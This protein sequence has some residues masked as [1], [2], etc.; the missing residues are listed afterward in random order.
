LIKQIATVTCT[1]TAISKLSGGHWASALDHTDYWTIGEAWVYGPVDSLVSGTQTYIC[2]ENP[3]DGIGAVA[4]IKTLTGDLYCV[5]SVTM[6][7]E[8]YVHKIATYRIV[9]SGVDIYNVC[10][11]EAG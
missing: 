1:Q 4:S 10:P 5:G 7:S 8:V 2:T 6:T 11:A 3:E 9:L